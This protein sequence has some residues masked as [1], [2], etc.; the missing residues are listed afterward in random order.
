MH[1][2]I[3]KIDLSRE[4]MISLLID[5]ANVNSGSE[6]LEGLK[7][8]FHKLKTSFAK[9][10]GEI[11]I[12]DLPPWRSVN[13]HGKITE[14]PL[15][16]SLIIRKHPNATKKIFL[17]GHMDIALA[18]HHPFLGCKRVDTNILQ[19]PGVADMKGGLV[20]M[21]KALETL[22]NSP[23][24][25]K[26]GWT[27]LLNSDEEISSPGSGPIFTKLAKDHQFGMVFEPAL[28][29]GMVVSSRKGSVNFSAVAKGVAAHAGRDFYLGKNALTT[30]AKFALAAES[31]NNREKDTTVNIGKIDGGG[32]V[33]IVPELGICRFNLRSNYPDEMDTAKKTLFKIAQEMNIEL[34][35]EGD[36]PVKPFDEKTQALFHRVQSHAK[37]YGFDLKWRHGGGVCDGN[38]MSAAGLPTIDTLG[39]IGFNLHTME[40]YALLESLTERAKWAASLLF[41]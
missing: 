29:D 5:W 18:P 40:E 27:V 15:G 6:N 8:M 31:L 23:L 14:T 9:L 36:K 20:I 35:Q 26:I 22:E 34:F 28:Y 10:E 39:V 37:Q 38:T 17:A 32:P 2:I 7:L 19:G 13:S 24:A 1:E 3:E 30:I 41:E 12:V 33:N 21:L 16:Q 11:E 25:G 4:E